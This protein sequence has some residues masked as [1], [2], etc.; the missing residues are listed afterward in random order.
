MTDNKLE[1]NII[2]FVAL[3]VTVM[4]LSIKYEGLTYGEI[5]YV[6]L[7]LTTVFTFIIASG[8]LVVIYVVLIVAL[9]S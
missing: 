6:D 3:I 2:T 1:A 5:I 9:Y 4:V 7:L 8:I